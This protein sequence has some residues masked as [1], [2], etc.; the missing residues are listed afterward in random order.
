LVASVPA[1]YA[2]GLRAAQS[3]AR[4]K[5]RVM[6]RDLEHRG[7]SLS[8]GG[9]DSTAGRGEGGRGSGACMRVCNREPNA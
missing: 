7:A 2:R 8:K 6:D 4:Q 5:D 1:L 3:V 9:E